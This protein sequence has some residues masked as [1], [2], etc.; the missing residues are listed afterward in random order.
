MINGFLVEVVLENVAALMQNTVKIDSITKRQ[1]VELMSNLLVL[2]R[3][4][5][6]LQ[7]VPVIKSF[8]ADR[9]VIVV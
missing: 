1:I 7:L 8:A 5:N 9:V 2:V 6:C 4:E 3:F